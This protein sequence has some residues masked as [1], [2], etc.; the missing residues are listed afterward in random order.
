ME[1][2]SGHTT[3]KS[4]FHAIRKNFR[5]NLLRRYL[6]LRTRLAGHGYP[7]AVAGLIWVMAPLWGLW[8]VILA[9]E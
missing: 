6:V 8:L 7:Q 4:A 3:Y 1:N 9:G 5:S 2:H